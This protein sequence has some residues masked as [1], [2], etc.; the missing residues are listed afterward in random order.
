MLHITVQENDDGSVVGLSGRLEG[1]SVAE[2]RQ[3]SLSATPPLVIDATELRD[4]GADGIALLMEL[5]T[6]GARVEG[7]SGYLTM[8]LRTLREQGE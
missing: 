8:R 2:A 1:E 3:A 5:M 7:L 4:A 6:E